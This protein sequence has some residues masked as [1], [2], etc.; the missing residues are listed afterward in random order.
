MWYGCRFM[1]FHGLSA[2]R[3]FY[4]MYICQ[5]YVKT[6]ILN[7]LVYCKNDILSKRYYQII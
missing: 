7:A 3:L 1:Q 5:T 4:L 2:T 6:K